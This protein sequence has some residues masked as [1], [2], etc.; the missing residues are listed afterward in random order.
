MNDALNAR[1]LRTQLSK[2]IRRDLLG[3]E[4]AGLTGAAQ[5]RQ[6]ADATSTVVP[7]ALRDVRTEG[8]GT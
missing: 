6:T 1:Q 8:N 5:G 3:I 4:Q 7:F 2:G